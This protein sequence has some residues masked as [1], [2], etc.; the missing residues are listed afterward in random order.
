MVTKVEP[1]TAGENCKQLPW[2]KQKG[3][4]LSI[5]V[6]GGEELRCCKKP[7]LPPLAIEW[8]LSWAQG[9]PL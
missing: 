6:F 4:C 5:F 9:I 7:L 3:C 2:R 1:K 8:K